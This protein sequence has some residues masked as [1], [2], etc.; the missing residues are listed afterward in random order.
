MNY[1][2]G[3]IGEGRAESYFLSEFSAFSDLL[4][5]AT[6]SVVSLR[7]K[8][9]D[10]TLSIETHPPPFFFSYIALKRVSFQ[11]KG[12]DREDGRL[13]IK[14]KSNIIVNQKT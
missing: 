4:A 13:S 10:R 1:E 12:F 11:R 2:L 7:L 6:S 8:G 3:I 14:E 9:Y 5:A